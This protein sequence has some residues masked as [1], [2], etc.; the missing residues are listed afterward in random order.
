LNVPFDENN[1]NVPFDENNLN[2]NLGKQ[3]ECA[4]GKIL[5]VPLERKKLWKK[6]ECALLNKLEEKIECP[7]WKWLN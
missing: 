7:L 1:L 6:L 4:L 2:V 3:I 5:N